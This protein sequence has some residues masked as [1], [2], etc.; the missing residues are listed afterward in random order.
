MILFCVDC[1]GLLVVVGLLYLPDGRLD[2]RYGPAALGLS[3]LLLLSSV[4]LLLLL[5]ATSWKLDRAQCLFVCCFVSH[6]YGNTLLLGS[7]CNSVTPVY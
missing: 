2:P 1:G 4:L 7:S 6:V 3:Q 5:A